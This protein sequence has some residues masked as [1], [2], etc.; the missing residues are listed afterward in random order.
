MIVSAI[1]TAPEDMPPPHPLPLKHSLPVI[2]SLI[3]VPLTSY[4]APESPLD[5]VV[6]PMLPT[7]VLLTIRA[8]ASPSSAPPL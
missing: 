4:I 2:V 7:N 6:P 8:G 5:D 3:S 1:D